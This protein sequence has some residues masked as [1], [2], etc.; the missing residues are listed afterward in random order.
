MLPDIITH[1]VGRIRIPKEVEMQ[2]PRVVAVVVG[3]D[4]VEADDFMVV[5]EA[6]AVGDRIEVGIEAVDDLTEGVAEAEAGI[7]HIISVN[8]AC[9]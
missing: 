6:T 3:E 5:E 1:K 8:K 2:T 7:T 9:V 4:F